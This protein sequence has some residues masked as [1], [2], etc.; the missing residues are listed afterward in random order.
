MTSSTAKDGAVVPDEH[1]RKPFDHPVL[2]SID[3]LNVEL[4]QTVVTKEKVEELAMAAGIDKV[5]RWKP[6]KVSFSTHVSP[7][8]PSLPHKGDKQT[9][10]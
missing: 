6:A 1:G 9:F 10:G 2:A 8:P 4:P 5:L 3:N 7:V